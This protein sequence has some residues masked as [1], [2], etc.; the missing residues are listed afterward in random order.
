MQG[1]GMTLATI[2]VTCSPLRDSRPPAVTFRLPALDRAATQPTLPLAEAPHTDGP[3]GVPDAAQRAAR[4]FCRALVEVLQ[5]RRGAS[6]L[7]PAMSRETW[8]LLDRTRDERLRPTL[9]VVSTRIQSPTDGVLEVSAHLSE[10]GTATAAALRLEDDGRWTCRALELAL[11][12][13]RL[14]RSDRGTS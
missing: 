9:T 5:G 3:S 1:R 13:G 14:R 10:A 4:A 2:A 7:I 12:A 8:S 6:T 11:D